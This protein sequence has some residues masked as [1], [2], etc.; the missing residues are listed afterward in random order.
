[1]LGF[2]VRETWLNRLEV[3]EPLT[4]L[5]FILSQFN[6]AA[7]RFGSDDLKDLEQGDLLVTMREFLIKLIEKFE[8]AHLVER[9]FWQMLSKACWTVVCQ[10][11]GVLEPK[12]PDKPDLRTLRD[13]LPALDEEEKQFRIALIK[14]YDEAW[15]THVPSGAQID[16]S[17]K[18]YQYF[19]VAIPKQPPRT[20]RGYRLFKREA[21]KE[22]MAT[23][24]K[25]AQGQ[26]LLPAW[27]NHF[28]ER[29]MP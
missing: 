5:T 9:G 24:L 17:R 19:F 22:P 20:R 10:E 6:K 21:D 18:Q 28:L 12:M 11:G 2:S 26:S 15:L 13:L 23:L 14:L 7:H 3:L 16:A 27:V 29:G 8:H 4:R 1:M 25:S